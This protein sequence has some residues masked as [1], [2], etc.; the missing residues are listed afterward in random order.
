MSFTEQESQNIT[1]KRFGIGLEKWRI[2]RKLTIS[3]AS[4]KTNIPELRLAGLERGKQ[5]HSVMF[6]E[7][8]SISLAYEIELG[9]VY[10]L[11]I[12]TKTI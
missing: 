8:E 2:D 11:A 3:E 10:S 5:N 6:W 9:V 7:I 12:G 1:D 4:K